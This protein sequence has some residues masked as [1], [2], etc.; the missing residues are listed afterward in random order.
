MSVRSSAERQENR[1]AVLALASLDVFSDEYQLVAENMRQSDEIRIVW[2]S[3]RR[4]EA[5]VLDL[6]AVQD[7]LV[8][9]KRGAIVTSIGKVGHWGADA[10]HESQGNN[11]Y[12]NQSS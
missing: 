7:I 6:W 1:L 3:Q 2:F 10:V 5:D 8:I 11:L 4:R 9:C 12:V